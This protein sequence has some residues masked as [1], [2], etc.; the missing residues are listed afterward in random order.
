MPETSLLTWKET[1]AAN[2]RSRRAPHANNTISGDINKAR[3]SPNVTSGTSRRPAC[4]LPHG[5][6]LNRNVLLD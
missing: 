4:T 5:L 2:A 1:G 6:Y 3:C